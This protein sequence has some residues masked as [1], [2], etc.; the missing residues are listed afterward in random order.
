MDIGLRVSDDGSI[1]VQL[2]VVKQRRN[3]AL[4]VD[5]S[6]SVEQDAENT[7]CLPSQYND[8]VKHVKSTR[9]RLFQP[10]CRY[11][12]SSVQPILLPRSPES[13][14]IILRTSDGRTLVWHIPDIVPKSLLSPV[15]ESLDTLPWRQ[16]FHNPANCD[17]CDK[18][19]ISIRVCPPQAKSH[20]HTGRHL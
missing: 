14:N 3:E 6:V 5:D 20:A 10:K 1:E 13:E 18:R 7:A 8:Q 12:R 15:S 19:E 17:N 4:R 16:D 9:Y 11:L 2:S